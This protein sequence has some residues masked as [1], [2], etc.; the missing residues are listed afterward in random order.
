MSKKKTV[1]KTNNNKAPVSTITNSL[2]GKMFMPNQAIIELANEAIASLKL[3]VSGTGNFQ[4]WMKVLHRVTVGSYMLDGYFKYNPLA[5]KAFNDAWTALVLIKT[6]VHV[7]GE[8]GVLSKEL[9]FIS[10][11]MSLTDEMCRELSM[12]SV[13]KVYLD[14]DA[15]YEQL[16]KDNIKSYPSDWKEAA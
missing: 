5:Q 11:A 10:L 3:M 2:L 16:V 8:F 14:T 7:T 6:R 9:N 4:D 15:Y 1:R 13:R 12:V